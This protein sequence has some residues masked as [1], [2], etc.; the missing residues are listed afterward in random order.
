MPILKHNLVI[1]LLKKVHF[2]TC[3]IVLILLFGS[4]EIYGI[5]HYNTNF[6]ICINVKSKTVAKYARLY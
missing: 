4:M 3:N 1:H 6:I 2:N 5:M